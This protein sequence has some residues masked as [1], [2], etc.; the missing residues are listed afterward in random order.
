MGKI[1]LTENIEPG[2][3]LE[4]PVINN[5]GQVLLGAGLELSE[6]HKKLLNV[7]GVTSVKITSEDETA[8]E[9][10]SEEEFDKAAEIIKERANWEPR[11]DLEKDLF[12]LGIYSVLKKMRKNNEQS[13]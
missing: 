5:F 11:N 10:Y 1:I 2:M 3:V 12:R 7:W 8:E 6:K 9:V 4:E 13:I